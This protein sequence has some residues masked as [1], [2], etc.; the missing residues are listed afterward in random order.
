MQHWCPA[1]DLHFTMQVTFDQ[2]I[3][4]IQALDLSAALAATFDVR[5]RQTLLLVT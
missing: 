1:R 2:R 5:S 4:R 3:N